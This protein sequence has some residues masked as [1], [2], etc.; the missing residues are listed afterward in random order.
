[1]KVVVEVVTD[2]ISLFRLTVNRAKLC[3]DVVR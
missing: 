1:M 3:D 2:A